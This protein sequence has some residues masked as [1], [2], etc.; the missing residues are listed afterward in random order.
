MAVGTVSRDRAGMASGVNGACRQVGAAFG[1]ELLGAILTNQYT[2]SLRENIS[3]LTVQHAPPAQRGMLS[4]VI[5]T[6]QNAGTFVGSTGLKHM[7]PQYAS[8]AHQP[9]FPHIQMI[10]QN[11][12]ISSMVDLFY[13]AAG[14]LG[15]GMFA[16]LVLVKKTD[17]Q[18]V[19][20]DEKRGAVEVSP[21]VYDGV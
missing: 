17:M 2:T 19:S 13:V 3:S 4:G 16:A 15:V 5:S 21:P 14:L 18:P 1:I 11:A 6:L 10:V 8:F 9:L 20:S 12:F 7:P